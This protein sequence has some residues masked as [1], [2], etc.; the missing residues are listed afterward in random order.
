MSEALTSQEVANLRPATHDT[1]YARNE[2]KV[3]RTNKGLL[4]CNCL[5]IQQSTFFDPWSFAV[6]EWP[7]I[8]QF[9]LAAVQSTI[10]AMWTICVASSQIAL[11]ERPH[12]RGNVTALIPSSSISMTDTEPRFRNATKGTQQMERDAPQ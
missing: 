6:F 5:I 4:D 7:H 9:M 3:L 10:A 11:N 8:C 12:R 2:S 1:K